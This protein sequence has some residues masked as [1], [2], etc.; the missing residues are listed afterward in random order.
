MSA[1]PFAVTVVG[2]GIV[3]LAVAW[4]A[5]AAGLS[6]LVVDPSPGCG[7]SRVSAGM[8]APV[9]EARAA[10]APLTRLGL[11]SL[12]RWPGFAEGLAAD[13]GLDG[14]AALGLRR[15][16]TLQVAFDADD[17]RALRE[18][19][20]VHRLLDLDSELLSGRQCREVVPMLT[21]RVRGGLRV[22][23]DWQVDPRLVVAALAVAVERRGGGLRAE[24]VAAVRCDP[25]GRV[26]GVELPDATLLRSEAAVLAAGASMGSIGGLPPSL[27]LPVRPVKGEVLR[28]RAAP[29]DE[30]LPLTV[31]G[32][33]QGRP[34]YLVP[35]QDGEIVV[36]ATMQEAGFDT[37]VR[38]GA[39][40]E[41][42]R[43]AVDL[44]PAL[45]ELPLEEATAG[46]RPATPDNGPLLGPAGPP[47]LHV[48]GGHFRH[49]VLLAPIT[50][51]AVLAGM[52]AGD[53][54]VEA[55]AFTPGRYS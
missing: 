19:A 37:S 1:S 25:G 35:R 48:A 10:E 3:G 41:L 52:G 50:A 11:A 22:P 38:A 53:P 30:L 39:M 27:R 51:D 42:L 4:R 16:G 21:P 12:R 26:V 2:A 46:L 40:L 29:G 33:V 7:A 44:V 14:P 54:P 23:G 47:G 18:L 49:G 31:R 45:A 32:V 5:A 20:A 36:G 6:V 17:L 8:L 55:A 9:T 43:A 13:A 34:L 15:E 24:R 28:L